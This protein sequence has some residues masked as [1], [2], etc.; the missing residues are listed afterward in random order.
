MIITADL[1]KLLRCPAT[2]QTLS[3]ADESLLA[4][5]NARH[6]GPKEELRADNK[7]SISECF[8]AALVRED[9]TLFYP[10]RDGIPVLLIEEAI[11]L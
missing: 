5:I 2:G 11:L 6:L 4:R 10:V 1:L 7:P 8:T 3:L 9:Q